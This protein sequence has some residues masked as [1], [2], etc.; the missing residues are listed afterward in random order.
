MQNGGGVWNFVHGFKK[1]TVEFCGINKDNYK[2]FVSDVE[3]AEMHPL[4]KYYSGII[5]NKLYLPYLFKDYPEHI[6]T[7]VY[8]K[9]ELGFLPLDNT[10]TKTRLQVSEFLDF[11]KTQRILVLKHITM[12]V[13]RGFML[14][15][16]INEDF[17]INKKKIN[18]EEL[19]YLLDSL[20]NYIVQKY[21]KQHS[22]FE[23]INPTSL[24]T[25]RFLL[26]Y[27]KSAKSFVLAR[28]FQR[29]GC[30]GNVVDNLGSGNGILVY[31]DPVSGTYEDFGVVNV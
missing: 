11:I 19:I 9:D 3:F 5:D 10:R 8:F 20:N 4:N 6:P 17:Y 26:V 2:D 7:I 21:V 23:S 15:E 12:E 29:F 25:L 1:S 14:L 24:N 22:F 18:V 28:C 30:N 27:S 16:Y 13:G 31:V